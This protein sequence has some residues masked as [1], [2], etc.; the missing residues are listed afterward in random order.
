LGKGHYQR[1]SNLKISCVQVV[2]L[3][4]GDI[5]KQ[6]TTQNSRCIPELVPVQVGA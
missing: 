4:S 2:L 1:P 3:G 5:S 6:P